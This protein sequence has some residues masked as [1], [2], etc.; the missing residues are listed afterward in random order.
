MARKSGTSDIRGLGIVLTGYMEKKNPVTGSYAKRFLV[1]THE[2]FHWFK[3][4]DGYDLF[5]E[6][7]G[8]VGI[9]TITSIKL[10]DGSQG[11]DKRV[12]E[13][14]SSTDRKRRYFRPL[15]DQEAD[16]ALEWVNAINSVV[17]C[18]KLHPKRRTTLSNFHALDALDSRAT[19]AANS[20]LI[21]PRVISLKSAFDGSEMVIARNPAWERVIVVP[22]VHP[23]DALIISTSNGGVATVPAEL[24]ADKYAEGG[25]FEVAI[26]GISLQT[27]VRMSVLSNVPDGD[28]TN[29]N[30]TNIY[31]T[32][33]AASTPRSAKT[34]AS[35]GGSASKRAPLEVDKSVA[36]VCLSLLEDQHSVITLLLAGAAVGVG[37]V[38]HDALRRE[39][40]LLFIACLA[41]A[42]YAS[43]VVINKARVEVQAGRSK[44]GMVGPSP[45]SLFSHRMN[46][47]SPPIPLFPTLSPCPA[48][49][50]STLSCTR[51]PSRPAPTTTC[52]AAGRGQ[53]RRTRTRRRSGAPF[54]SGSSTAAGA[55]W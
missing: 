18:F 48:P 12:F 2:S 29:A 28:I 1:L 47:A 19:T 22:F 45:S 5:G 3:R 27:A 50:S 44:T 13:I 15:P 35:S 16:K 24:M 41:L 51:T 33:A 43:C 8:H 40:M 20:D 46:T 9:G 14:L 39:T 4:D 38:C 53:R 54:L 26:Q 30:S 25:A 36:S 23:G 34:Q 42:G 32:A 37:L 11:A 17:E 52:P 21:V 49:R 10:V 6:E 55:T 31:T 7:R